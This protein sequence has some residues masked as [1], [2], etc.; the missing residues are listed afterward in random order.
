MLVLT[1]KTSEMIKIGET[2]VVKV[3]HAGKNTVKIGI[4][5]PNEVRILRG[6]L[7]EAPADHPLAAFLK[8][9]PVVRTSRRSAPGAGKTKVKVTQAK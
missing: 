1:R 5:A 8:E 2:I 4:E 9:R 3:I 6:E 7:C